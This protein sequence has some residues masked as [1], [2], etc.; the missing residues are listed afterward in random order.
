MLVPE[1]SAARP[2]LYSFQDLVALRSMVFLRAKTSSQRLTKAWQ[3]LGKLNLADLVDHPSE[4]SFGS[5]GKRIFVQTPNEG[6]VVDLTENVGNSLVRF[7]FEELFNEFTDWRQRPVVNFQRPSAHIE[8]N[9]RRLGGWPTI[10]GT[11][12]PYD[13][14]SSLVDGDSVT[15]DEVDHYYPGI[16]QVQA[17][18][19]IRFDD[20]VKAVV[21]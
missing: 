7:T 9:P 8:V 16:S 2:P 4:Y 10:E 18:D 5:D 17:R 3:S 19:A 13:L 11:R 12:I 1:V 15:V 14:I 20:R 6:P 21:V